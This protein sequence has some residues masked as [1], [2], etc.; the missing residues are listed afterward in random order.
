[1]IET[2]VFDSFLAD[3][4][5]GSEWY[6]LSQFLGGMA[7]PLFLFLV[8]VSLA[9][10]VDRLHEKAT[11]HSVLVEKVLRRSGWIL[12]LAYAFRL[13]QAAEWYPYSQWGQVL[14]VDILNC[15]ALSSFSVGLA[16]GIFRNRRWNAALMGVGAAVIVTL[17]PWVFLMRV[18]MSTPLLDYLNGGG[19]PNY[20]MFFSWG[21][22]AFAGA[23]VGFL[24]RDA[25]SRNDEERFILKAGLAGVCAYALGYI[26]NWYPSL[27][28]GFFNY[29]LT[30]PEYFLVRLGYMMVF[31]YLA[32]RWSRR[33]TAARWSPLL[34][35]GQTSLLIYWV[36]IEFVYG[37][38]RYFRNNLSVGYTAA[39]LLWLI[40]LMLLLA[41]LRSNWQR[42]SLWLAPIKS[43]EQS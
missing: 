8:G 7:A 4:Y 12:F 40:P 43:A 13:Q 42:F 3:R 36:H 6:W 23:S 5:R 16:G 38:L 30:S 20:F 32:Y 11:P 22:F 27:A 25:R 31:L 21:G 18:G 2:H 37:R 33:A 17:T 1:M 24:L 10:V 19:H 35:F 41:V 15:L 29:S 14:K 34:V 28:Y 9:I 39:Q 26:G